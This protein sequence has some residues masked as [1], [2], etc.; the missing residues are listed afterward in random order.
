MEL[1]IFVAV[2]NKEVVH[3]FVLI[4]VLVAENCLPA[5]SRA[6]IALGSHLHVQ[7]AVTHLNDLKIGLLLL[8]SGK[9]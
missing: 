4:V 7:L 6:L 3:M 8:A 2:V 1:L 5:G 9:G